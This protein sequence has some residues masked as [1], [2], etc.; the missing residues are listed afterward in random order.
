L[1]RRLKELGWRFLRHGGKHDVW[2]NG[3]EFEYIPRHKEI[4]ERLAR[5]ILRSARIAGR[6]E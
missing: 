2:T 4:N 3:S 6:E 1:E 5:K